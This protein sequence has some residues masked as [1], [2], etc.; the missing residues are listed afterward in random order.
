MT[1]NP[2]PV[3]RLAREL[4]YSHLKARGFVK[5]GKVFLRRREKYIESVQLEAGS[6]TRS[7]GPWYFGITIG[8]LF[9]DLPRPPRHAH[10]VGDIRGLVPNV[11]WRFEVNI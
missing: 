8:A 4:H 6:P 5:K 10:A 9:E 7:P 11:P 3:D 1:S 2:P